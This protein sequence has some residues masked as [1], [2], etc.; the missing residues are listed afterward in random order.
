MESRR[1][2]EEESDNKERLPLVPPRGVIMEGELSVEARF[3]G[4]GQPF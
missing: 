1:G 2:D 3:P 4:Q